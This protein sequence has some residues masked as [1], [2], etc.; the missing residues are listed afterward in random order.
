MTDSPLG[1]MYKPSI[2]AKVSIAAVL[3]VSLTPCPYD[4]WLGILHAQQLT[5][6]LVLAAVYKSI[7]ITF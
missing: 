5:P 4:P 2:T 7:V 3:A 6:F 1:I